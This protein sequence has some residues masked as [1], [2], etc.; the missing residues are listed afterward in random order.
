MSPCL[1]ATAP[2]L[3]ETA[4]ALAQW[5]STRPRSS[6][7]PENLWS[8]ATELAE[9]YGVAKVAVALKLDYKSLKRRLA[10]RNAAIDACSAP[11]S[12]GFVELDL[13]LPLAP[14][15]CVLVLTD[16]AGRALRIELPQAASSH[17]A[18]VSRS[19]TLSDCISI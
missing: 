19:S 12:P 7:I 16:Q 1:P 6:R 4:A 9:R 18:E 11:M 8:Q 14:P 13:G 17:L 2:Q 10:A 3:A 5:R 15:V